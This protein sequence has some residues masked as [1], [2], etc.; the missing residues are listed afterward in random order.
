MQG[1][2]R[3]QRFFRLKPFPESAFDARQEK[4][5]AVS[6]ERVG[7]DGHPPFGKVDADLVCSGCAWMRFDRHMPVES[8]RHT[9][10]GH[11]I[12]PLFPVDNGASLHVTVGTEGQVDLPFVLLRCPT[13]DRDVVLF[14]LTPLELRVQVR[15]D[16]GRP[17]KDDD[18]A[19]IPVQPMHHPDRH[20]ICR[21]HSEEVRDGL[22]IAV[23]K[24]EQPGRL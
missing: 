2:P 13:T 16:F 23:R 9:I 4:G 21:Q 3:Q 1:G 10:V 24:N 18:S 20:V 14:H 12:L 19:R 6:V 15:M 17:G 5:F 11:T 8:F 7:N 22:V